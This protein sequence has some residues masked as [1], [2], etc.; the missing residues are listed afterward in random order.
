MLQPCGQQHRTKDQK[1]RDRHQLPRAFHKLADEMQVVFVD[2]AKHHPCH[3][4]RDKPV[5]ANRHSRQIRRKRAGQKH[6]RLAAFIGPVVIIRAVH[7]PCNPAPNGD[8]GKRP[9]NHLQ[10]RILNKTA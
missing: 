5:A 8:P 10:H 1:R 2:I 3:K 4:G 9:Q 6:N 7:H